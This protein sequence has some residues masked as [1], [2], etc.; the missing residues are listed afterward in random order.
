MIKRAVV[1]DFGRLTDDHAHAMVDEYPAAD[2]RAR[3]DLD[4]GQPPSQMRGQ[5]GQPAQLMAPQPVGESMQG[6]GM[7]ARVTGQDFPGRARGRVALEHA[8]D[9]FTKT[10]EHGRIPLEPAQILKNPTRAVNL[11]FP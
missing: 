11:F 8:G 9:V 2:G 3:M 5:A 6:Q 10:R 1:G 7:K 4:T